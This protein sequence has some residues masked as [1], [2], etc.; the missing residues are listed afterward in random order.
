[1][2][3]SQTIYRWLHRYHI[4]VLIAAAVATVVGASFA[5][6]LPFESDFAAL[7]PRRFPSVQALE[8]INEQ[9][10]GTS[11]LRIALESQDF[12]AATQL[13]AALEP[14]LLAD[15]EKR[16]LNPLLVDD[17]FGEE[18]AAES[19]K[20]LAEWEAEY[21]NE[22]P[23][24]YYINADSSVLV[25]RVYP[26]ESDA[27]L[28]FVRNM[29]SDVKQLVA[30]VQRDEPSTAQVDVFYGGSLQNRV[31]EFETA[32]SDIL[33][34]AAYG[35]GGVFLL[36]V[37]YFRMFL[38]ALVISVSLLCSLAWTF[39]I[40]YLVIGNLNTITG[41]L[42]VILFGLGIDYGI[43]VFA[44]Y[45]EGRRAGLS[46]EA[47]VEKAVTKTGRAVATTAVTTAAAFFALTP[48]DFRGFS[49]LGFISGIGILFALI[50]MVLVLPALILLVERIG[51]LRI[52]PRSNSRS[53]LTRRPLS[54]ARPLVF[55]AVPATLVAVYLFAHVP[56][57]YDFTNLRTMSEQRREFGTKI[58]GI[59]TLSESPAIVLADSREDVDE[60]ITAVRAKMG[61]DTLSPTIKTVRSIFSLV[62]HDQEQRLER[63]RRIRRL[64]TDEAEGVVTGEDKERIDELLGYLQVDEPFTWD[65]FPVN[66]KRQF[67]T[68]SGEV[69]NFVFVYPSVSMSDG[70]NA[71]AFR[72]DVG[73]IT[74][75]SGK[76][77]HASSPSI[78]TAD[79]LSVMIREGRMAVV[80][81]F[82]VVCL[83]VFA[84]VRSIKA[85]ALVM[86]PLVVGI[87][88]MGGLMY[89]FGL[90]LNFF[91]VVVFP[92]V[93]GIGVDNGVHIHHRYFEEG[94]R[95]LWFVLR[96]TGLVIAMTTFTTIVGYSGLIVATHPGLNSIGNLAVIGLSATFLTAVLV[97][98]AILQLLE[99]RQPAGGAGAAA[100][101]QA[102]ALR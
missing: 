72:D 23:K 82:V 68:K 85:A 29:V 38:G 31:E 18:P 24:E 83:I 3:R 62:P 15:A 99:G 28:S 7:L 79:M 10:G 61:Q 20:G 87:L 67:L 13:A 86:C 6:R 56:F 59:F 40:T 22:M 49:D 52:S 41:F 60:I 26:S 21:E 73:E 91:N 32:R 80:L 44:R 95:S 19:A 55:I 9:V 75:N 96:T 43:H 27:N 5:V 33:G 101:V 51:L 89:I 47:A 54:Y 58:T 84:G 1:M 76:V 17:L 97:L 64:V 92:S 39:G 94:P 66:D 57:E 78:I 69:G 16:K 11:N 102:T 100:E 30:S 35:V 2:I 50:A 77:F 98:P 53:R 36:I 65:D 8:R 70:R 81:T 4:L 42:F 48:M 12:G 71:M 25:V 37:L 46:S 93:I 88:W 74:T 90:K 34:T 63:V 45:V 14:R